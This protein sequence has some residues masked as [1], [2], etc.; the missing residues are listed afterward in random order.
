LCE[1]E[2]WTY[3]SRE[4]QRLRVFEEMMR[5]KIF[6]STRDEVRGERRRLHIEELHD[7]YISPDIRVIYSRRMRWA[8]H[9]EVMGD[10]RGAYTVSVERPEER[11]SL[12]RGK[13]RLEDNTKV[14]L[15]EVRRGVDWI[16][17]A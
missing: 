8:G 10:R 6:W 2:D 1:C 14:E 5:R 12:G 7:V 9:V 13:C 3:I 17:L 11:R 16:K 4:E 15:K